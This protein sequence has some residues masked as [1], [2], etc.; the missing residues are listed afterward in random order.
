MTP[1]KDY[2][3]LSLCVLVYLFTEEQLTL[4]LASGLCDCEHTCESYSHD[5]RSRY[6]TGYSWQNFSKVLVDFL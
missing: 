3:V 2:F 4:L 1:N 6:V 5:T